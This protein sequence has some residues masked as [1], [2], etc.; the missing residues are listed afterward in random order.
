MPWD[1]RQIRVD[2]GTLKVVQ[3]GRLRIMR[4]WQGRDIWVHFPVRGAW[5]LVDHDELIKVVAQR[6]PYL[7]SNS[8]QRHGAYSTGHPSEHLMAGL[9]DYRISATK[10]SLLDTPRRR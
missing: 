3:P 8:W 5:Y 7:D 6:A 9:A 1:V 10:Q 2:G 4:A